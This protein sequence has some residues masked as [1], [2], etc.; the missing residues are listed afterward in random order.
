[1]SEAILL[2]GLSYRHSGSDVPALN[3]VDLRLDP[4]EVLAMIG[5]SGAGKST[6]LSILDGQ[7]QGWQ[8]AAIV[9]GRALDPQK[10]PKR[11]ARVDVGF[12]FQDLALVDRS[13]SRQNVLNGRLGRHRGLASL[14][15]Q[16]SDADR[17]AAETALQEAGIGELAD[18]RV[19]QL[20]GGQRQRVAIARCLAQEPRL[21][22]ADEPVSSLDPARAEAILHLI[23]SLAKKRGASVIFTS[24]Q[25][26]LAIQFSDRVLGLQDGRVVFDQSAKTIGKSQIQA[27]Y[28]DEKMADQLRLVG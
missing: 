4:G 3:G 20:S 28:A 10:A 12:I 27:L 21:I 5:P 6:L 7:T 16:F 9:L 15:G 14:M 17:A 11:A 24:H 2:S 19:D 8:G 23:T 22:L 25:P 1:M 13:T 18:R 26:E